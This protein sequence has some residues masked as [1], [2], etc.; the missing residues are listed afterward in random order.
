MA[1]SKLGTLI[2]ISNEKNNDD[3]DLPFVGININ[4]EFMPTVANVDNVDKSKYKIICKNRFI[5]SGMQTGR[6]GCIRLGFYQEEKPALVSPA[7]TT[8]EVTSDEILPEYLFMIFK[9]TEMDRYGAFLSVASIRS[10]LDW[11]VFCDIDLDLPKIEIQRKYVA[12]YKAMQDN[13]KVYQSKLDDIKL[14]YEGYI[15]N[16]RKT[17]TPTEIGPYIEQY[18]EKNIS[19]NT[20]V[21]GV[22]SSSLFVE[23]K[24]NMTGI[25]LTKYSVVKEKCFAYNPSRINLGS[26]ALRTGEDCV[27]SPMYEIFKVC[28]IDELLP[29]YLFVWLTRKEFLRSTLFYAIGSVRDTFDFSLMKQVKIPIPKIEIQ[30]DIIK[31]HNCYIER[32][33]IVEK[34]KDKINNICPILIAGAVKEAKNG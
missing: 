16:L 11:E 10:N 6:D 21:K 24:A 25:D 20:N 2:T 7:Y 12:I 17:L 23:T 29:E 18:N 27:I 3:L 33:E 30:E 19:N 32:K 8:F 31:I 4:K 9:S 1:L 13:L 28:K 15:E 14:S 26:I 34:L 22:D 5:F